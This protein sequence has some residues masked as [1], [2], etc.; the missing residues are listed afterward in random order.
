LRPSIRLRPVGDA[1]GIAVP[2]NPRPR[3]RRTPYLI[4]PAASPWPVTLEPPATIAWL[5][6]GDGAPL[7]FNVAT[8]LTVRSVGQIGSA[9]NWTTV[10]QRLLIFPAGIPDDWPLN[11][12]AA[13][14]RYRLDPR[15]EP[16]EQ[17][18]RLA[19]CGGPMLVRDGETVEGLRDDRAWRTA[20]GTDRE[21]RRVWLIVLAHGRDGAPGATLAEAAE[22]LRALGAWTAI[23]FDGGS[24]TSILFPP[25][26]ARLQTL[27]PFRRPI[28]HGLLLRGAF[29]G[30]K[31][32]PIVE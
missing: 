2:I 20:V 5:E 16:L 8:T 25:E 21:G 7:Q 1:A 14:V 10:T 9:V 31:A 28:H 24:S 32:R 6:T 12:P 26:E 19:T 11:L 17:P 18:V 29:V 4:D 30:P 27:F 3:L 15:L 22:T 23:N 13:G